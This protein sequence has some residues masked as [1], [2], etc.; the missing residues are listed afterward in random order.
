[1]PAE[2]ILDEIVRWKRQETAARQQ[3]RPLAD[4]RAQS[5][6]GPPPRDLAASNT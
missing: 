3:E 5:R 1:M 4:V 2:T 6:R